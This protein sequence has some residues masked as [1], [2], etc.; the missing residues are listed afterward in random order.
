MAD[1]KAARG[2]ENEDDSIL[3]RRYE[4][5]ALRKMSGTPNTTIMA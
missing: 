5:N 2:N 3:V 1:R 4:P